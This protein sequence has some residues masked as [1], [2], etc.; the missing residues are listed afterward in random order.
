MVMKKKQHRLAIG[1]MI[2]VNIV[3]LLWCVKGYGIHYETDDD[4]SMAAI[5]AGAYGESSA[6]IVYGNIIYGWFLK[7]LY[8]IPGNHLNW[9]V[10]VHY[11]MM[12]L[13]YNAIG[14]VLLQK[15]GA[16]KGSVLFYSFLIVFCYGTYLSYTFTKVS[17]LLVAAGYALLFYSME[18]QGKERF[19]TVL[20][21]ILLALYG[22]LSRFLPFFMISAFAAGPWLYALFT[23]WKDSMRRKEFIKRSLPLFAMGLLVIG[24][25]LFSTY[26]YKSIPEW[27]HYLEYNE[28]R[29]ELLDYDLPDYETHEQEYAKLGIS[30]NDYYCLNNWDFGDPVVFSQETL[31]KILDLKEGRGTSWERIG[32]CLKGIGSW[33]IE[34]LGIFVWLLAVWRLFFEKKR[35]HVVWIMLVCLLEIVYL[36]YIGRVL[37]RVTFVIYL[38]AAIQLLCLCQ[39]GEQDKN[40]RARISRIGAIVLIGVSLLLS[41]FHWKDLTKKAGYY[42]KDQTLEKLQ[43][44]KESGNLYVW[45]VRDYRVIFEAY[46]IL[47]AMN[48]GI[49]ENSVCLGGW[50]MESPFRNQILERYEVTNS[51]EA[52]LLDPDVFLGGD[53]YIGNKIQYLREHVNETA[54]FSVYQY[55]EEFVILAFSYN[56]EEIRPGAAAFDI[57]SIEKDEEK[58]CMV[59]RGTTDTQDIDHLYIQIENKD[60]GECFT[61]QVKPIFIEDRTEFCLM[62]PQYN[63]VFAENMEA[64]L[65]FETEEA[66]YYGAQPYSFSWGD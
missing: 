31:E 24:S 9:M 23:V 30:L 19:F 62:V 57:T 11:G 10:L 43:E 41:P 17:G 33:S 18:T 42:N 50:M 4:I 12:F 60:M 27:N 3:V 22:S 49:S 1:I 5:L 44:L 66:Y 59:F 55:E 36:Y 26:I 35:F 8:Q 45:D 46:N 28:I 58:E 65:V 7:L 38:G 63:M 14:Y 61:F 53:M 40:G 48:R 20:S 15:N 29:S 56:F 64:R 47:N 16:K 34:Y 54:N 37:D 13:A 6:F 25:Q 39:R 52:L 2:I 21:G 51:F 32:I